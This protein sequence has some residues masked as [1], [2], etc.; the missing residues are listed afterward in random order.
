MQNNRVTRSSIKL[1]ELEVDIDF[2][3]AATEWNKNKRLIGN[4]HYKYICSNTTNKSKT[5]I[6]NNICYKN[7]E[8]CWIHRNKIS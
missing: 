7:S 6:C 8:K 3:N 4:G 2:K 5:G 1:K